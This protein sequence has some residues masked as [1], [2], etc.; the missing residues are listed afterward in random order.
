MFKNIFI[1]IFI[2]FDIFFLAGCTT[3][4]IYFLLDDELENLESVLRKQK[5]DLKTLEDFTEMHFNLSINDGN[6]LKIRL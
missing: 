6:K 2:W 1:P 4:S 5:K 3:N